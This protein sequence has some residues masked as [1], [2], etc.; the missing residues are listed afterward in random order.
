MG[1]KLNQRFA[2]GW[3]VALMLLTCYALIPHCAQGQSPIGIEALSLEMASLRKIEPEVLKHSL[4]APGAA[5]RVLVYMAEQP[6]LPTA[7]ALA[8]MGSLQRRQT[9]VETL[10]NAARESQ[11]D[12]V[13][14]LNG[15][16]AMAQ[17]HDVRPYWVF[18][19]LALS[20][21]N[22][23]IWQLARRADVRSIRP[24]RLR[25]LPEEAGQ[26]YTQAESVT[27]ANAVEWNIQTIRADQVWHAL[28][29][30]GS[31][32][33]V[34][35]MDT[36]V[37]WHHP[38]LFDKY[39][40]NLG[41]NLYDHRANW[42]CTTNE[43]Y[44]EPTD[45]HGHGTHTMGTMVG[46]SADRAAFGVAPGARWI[47]VKIFSDEGIA[48]DSWIHAGFEW[49]LDPG[50]FG[51]P[52]LAPDV[53]NN[54]WGSS[55]GFDETFR[56]DV[57][58]WRA[59]GIV[60]IFSAG[61][62]GPWDE[63]I[64]SPGSFPESIT[65]GATNAYDYIAFFSSRGPSPWGLKPDVAAPGVEVVSSLPGGRYGAYSGTS[66]AAPHLAGLSALIFQ[67]NPSISVEQLRE[68]LTSTAVRRGSPIPNNEYGWGRIDAYQAVATAGN[69]GY[70]R[71]V[72]RRSGSNQPIAGAEVLARAFL[73]SEG[74]AQSVTDGS[75]RFVFPVAP[76]TYDLTVSAFGYYP[77][78]VSNVTVV[79]GTTVVRD[80][81]LSP[82]PTGRLQGRIVESES[83]LPISATV[84]IS[85][86]PITAVTSPATGEYFVDLPGGTYSVQVQSRGHQ[87]GWAHG[88]TV[89]AGQTVARDFALGRM[90]TILLVDSG[91]WYMDSQA[92][93]FQQALDDL[94]YFYDR[95]TIYQIYGSERSVPTADELTRYDI[96]IWSCPQDS[97]GYIGAW[98]AL[99]EYL[100][101]G[102]NLFLTGQDIGYWDNPSGPFRSPQYSHYVRA[103]LTH[104]D[105]GSRTLIGTD[106]QLLQGLTLSLNGGDGADNQQSPDAI[107]PLN[108]VAADGLAS[109][110]NGLSGAQVVKNCVPYRLIYFAFGFEGINQ[111][112]TRREVMRRV[113][114]AFTSL[115]P[116]VAN[117]LTPSAQSGIQAAG[118][119][120]TYTLQVHNLNPNGL[121][122]VYNLS[123][124][125][126]TWPSSL[127]PSTATIT[128]CGFTTITVMVTVP[129]DVG[130]QASDVLMV[131]ARSTLSPT[132]QAAAVITTS[133]PAPV[134]LVDD[135]R[136]YDMEPFYRA[137]LAQNGLPYD[138]WN[139]GWKSGEWRGSPPASALQMY[140]MVIWFTGYDWAS[141]LTQQ[142]EQNLAHALDRGS[143]LFLI[144]QDYLFVRDLTPFGRDYLGVGAY[145]G[146]LTTT[147]V[148][149]MRDNS[150]TRLVPLYPLAYPY[151]N[152][153]DALSPARASD[154]ALEGS[155]GEP[156]ALTH[157]GPGFRTSFFAF[158]FEAIDS[159]EGR[160]LVMRQISGWLSWLGSST[161][162][163][164]DTLVPGGATVAYTL[165]LRNDG[166][167]PIEAVVSN[168]LPSLL[169]FEPGSLSPPEAHYD[170][171][172]GCIA[173]NRRLAVGEQAQMSYCTTVANPLPPAPITNIVEVG[174]DEH[175]VRFDL[176][177]R[178][179]V[180]APDLSASYLAVDKLAVEPGETLTYTISLRNDGISPAA[181]VVLTNPMPN[182]TTYLS[183]SL[184]HEG[185]G[186][187]SDADGLISWAGSLDAGEMVTLT[188]RAE[189]V[190]AAQRGVT[191]RNIA[192]LWDGYAPLRRLEARTTIS[193]L[194]IWLP[195]ILR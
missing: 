165:T 133:S 112:E 105:S 83:G 129:V 72:V 178:L 184:I 54:S 5:Q 57:R 49:L 74:F 188:Y 45:G 81:S 156:I 1:M 126:H 28:N 99:A 94:N 134:L 6:A 135:D 163:A 101:R 142:D 77:S 32:V 61:N 116:S 10:R 171:G 181:S 95:R 117:R 80:F 141:P 152:R 110:E 121:P 31:G 75:G 52:T 175:H 92:I 182:Y 123:L 7:D 173:W 177:H 124:A 97:P 137:A 193:P 14:F 131:S 90:P 179:D 119:A 29:M 122:D 59:A 115:P 19:G 161:F 111:R 169:S 11:R 120:I 91:A 30:D 42:L 164:S 4:S 153:S 139:V 170:A 127:S 107:A 140:P 82:L 190:T 159:A 36:G 189:V 185:G 176:A 24:D 70:L 47:A 44:A 174:Y 113:I 15:R 85:G 108:E 41:K 106:G 34:A 154:R 23:T 39:R 8:A 157:V 63:T 155:H 183:G 38:A 195:V 145:M 146:E 84:I 104:D 158:P 103:N 149:G 87:V 3:A 167:Q 21:S 76:W 102:G 172:T 27:E 51:N 2:V 46:S 148:I 17:V 132:L 25:Y 56:P 12:V 73:P 20:A 194:L 136:W 125:G 35:N 60:P 78:T 180:N 130:W 168:C 98:D 93:Y 166:W 48:Y 13:Q 40:G 18:N 192:Y 88:V 26:A 68:I 89:A 79:G 96:V 43:G 16:A 186:T 100:E 187:A 50:D 62:D 22:E 191:I 71:G 33:V 118:Q 58:A 162:T 143:N 69:P 138:Y 160:R 64:G 66:M 150:I 37:D 128:A 67:A 86:T 53:V 109:Y 9:V 55:W 65:A 147:H 151:P 114:D 144:S